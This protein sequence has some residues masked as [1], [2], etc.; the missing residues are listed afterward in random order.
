MTNGMRLAIIATQVPFIIRFIRDGGGW[1]Y[2]GY[3]A[4]IVYA[5]LAIWIATSR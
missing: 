5:A 4:G 2:V 3:A 1:A